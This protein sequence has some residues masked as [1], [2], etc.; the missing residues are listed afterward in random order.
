MNLFSQPSPVLT[1]TTAEAAALLRVS[2]ETVCDYIARGFLKATRVGRRWL[3]ERDSVVRV[4]EHGTCH[5]LASPDAAGPPI[6]R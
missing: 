4:L 6:R 3:I 5:L 2:P 1:L